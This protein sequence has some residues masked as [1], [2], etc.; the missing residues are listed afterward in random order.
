MIHLV[1]EYEEMCL[2]TSRLTRTLYHDVE[3][4]ILKMHNLHII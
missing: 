2:A 1:I 3:F 4:C